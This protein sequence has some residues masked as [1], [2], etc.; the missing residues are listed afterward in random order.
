MKWMNSGMAA[1]PDNTP[2]EVW[3]GC[4]RKGSRLINQIV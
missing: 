3:R 1:D 4:R 2:E